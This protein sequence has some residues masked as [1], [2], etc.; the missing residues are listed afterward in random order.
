MGL[1]GTKNSQ[2]GLGKAQ[3]SWGIHTSQFQNL[4]KDK[5]IKTV[6]AFYWYEIHRWMKGM[7]LRPEIN[8]YILVNWFSSRILRQFNER[9][10]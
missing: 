10:K 9:N 6:Y 5:V 7:E 1:Q 8:S 2:Y 3:K 4:Y